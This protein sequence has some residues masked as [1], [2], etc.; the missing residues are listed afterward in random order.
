ML[1]DLARHG[2]SAS[3]HLMRV[4]TKIYVQDARLFYFDARIPVSR[5][6]S[7]GPPVVLN[8]TVYL[9]LVFVT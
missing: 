5:A 7:V 3:L 4:C 6:S 8:R 1:P 2:H 9:F